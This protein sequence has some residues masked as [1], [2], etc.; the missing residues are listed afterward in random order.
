[1]V[2]VLKFLQSVTQNVGGAGALCSEVQVK[3]VCTEEGVRAR[4]PIQEGL[5]P[6]VERTLVQGSV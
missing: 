6:C 2:K 4:D 1:M 5:G 3:Q